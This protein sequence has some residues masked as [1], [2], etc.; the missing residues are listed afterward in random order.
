MLLIYACTAL[1]LAMHVSA[2]V[3][4]ALA[5]LCW[6]QGLP[7][8]QYLWIVPCIHVVKLKDSVY[9]HTHI[10]Q[11]DFAVLCGIYAHT[12]TTA[13]ICLESCSTKA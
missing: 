5:T 8:V 12:N 4:Q 2:Y 13:P 11:L 10:A 3:F 6:S 9:K 7:N 1:Q